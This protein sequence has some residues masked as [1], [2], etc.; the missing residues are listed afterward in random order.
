[1]V[2]SAQ[3]IDGSYGNFPYTLS[4]SSDSFG[5]AAVSIGDLDGDG[6]DDLVVGASGDADD[7][8]D[9][10]VGAVYI[11]FLQTDG[12]VKSAQKISNTTGNFPFPLANS[13]YFGSS[14]GSLGD[15]DGDGV[16]DIAIG[17]PGGSV[18]STR[19]SVFIIFL[20]TDGLV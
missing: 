15:L 6:V 5:D 14:A 11:T 20:T 13:G 8:L 19:G 16:N 18:G 17:A 1:M 9:Y 7:Y 12:T 2:T 10:D 3:K 4:Y